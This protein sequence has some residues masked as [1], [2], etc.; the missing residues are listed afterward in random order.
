MGHGLDASAARA[1]PGVPG[2][3]EG[4]LRRPAPP[5][6]HS[7][8]IPLTGKPGACSA[9]RI[10][11]AQRQEFEVRHYWHALR[12]ACLSSGAFAGITGVAWHGGGAGSG[13]DA[14]CGQRWNVQVKWRPL[15]C[16]RDCAPAW[17][18]SLVIYG[19]IFLWSGPDELRPCDERG[20]CEEADG[21]CVMLVGEVPAAR[22][23][24]W[25]ALTA[26]ACALRDS[27]S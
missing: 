6:S 21:L 18:L 15:D 12:R 13:N 11:A 10:T 22:S 4:R 14:A 1:V 26:S 7:R 5:P 25:N 3:P 23:R 9:R 19:V 20:F 2:G 24:V 16:A 8:M 27:G 17:T